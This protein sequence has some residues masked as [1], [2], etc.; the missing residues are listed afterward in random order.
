MKIELNYCLILAAYFRGFERGSIL[1]SQDNTHKINA[2]SFE[3]GYLEPKGE[4]YSILV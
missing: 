1:P 3:Y 2:V 4:K